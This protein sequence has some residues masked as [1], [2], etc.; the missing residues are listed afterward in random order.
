M[1]CRAALVAVVWLL[2]ITAASAQIDNGSI[3]GFTSDESDAA[4][5]G[6]T[7]TATSS[8][9]MGRRTV[10]SDQH[11]YYRLLDLPP[12]DYQLEAQLAG[13]ARFERRDLVIQAGLS[14]QLDFKMRIG[15][16][17]EAVEVRSEAPILETE[18]AMSTLHLAGDFLRAL[19]L[20][21]GHDW[22]D[23]LR[24]APGAVL[25][26]G[27]GNQVET[28]GATLSSNV[29][30]LDGIDISEP[31]QNWPSFTELSPDSVAEIGIT[32][33]GH[34]AS[35]R[36]AMGAQLGIVTRSGGN[37]THGTATVDL[38]LRGLN[39]TNVPG[40]TPADR[41]ITRPSVS[42]GGPIVR[43]RL[44]Y[45]ATYRYIRERDGVTRTEDDLAVLRLFQ[46]GFSPF[47]A[48]LRSHQS[49]AK[50]TYQPTT[51][52]QVVLS[53]QFN[54]SVRE[55]DALSPRFTHERDGS[56]RSGGPVYS[57]M[58]RRLIGGRAS[59]E[60]QAGFSSKPYENFLQGDGPSLLIFSS[61][62]SSGGRLIGSGAPI[63][64]MGNSQHVTRLLQRRSNVNVT[65]KY[66]P[67]E[68]RGSHELTLGLNLLPKSEYSFLFTSSNGGFILEDRVLLDSANAGRG[69]RPFHRRHVSPVTLAGDGRSS[70]TAGFFAQDSWR[71]GR[72]WVVNAGLRID[73]AETFD[74]WGDSIQSS[75]QS[76]PRLGITYRLTTDGRT[77]VRGALNRMHDAIANVFTFS[78]G[79]LRQELRDE[80]DLDGDGSFERAFTL[81][82]VL[83][84]PS[85]APG[86]NRGLASPGLRQPL[87]DEI[88]L[89]VS[90][91]LPFKIIADASFIHR[92]Y[93]DRMVA[94]DTN[95]IYENGRFLGYRNPMFNQ[96]FEVRNGADNW[97]VYRALEL[98]LQKGFSRDLRF[99]IGYSHAH[100][101]ID[102][103]W[104]HND[105]ASV[106]QPE[107]FPNRKGIGSFVGPVMGQ[108]NSLDPAQFRVVNSGVPPHLLKVN[109]AY[110][111]PFGLAVGLSHL[112]QMGQYSGPI[113]T[114]LPR[115]SV[116]HPPTVTLSN[117]RVVSNPLGTPVRFFYPTR[118]EGQL[119]L[120][121]LNVLNLR[122]G[123]RFKRGSH[124]LEGGLEVFN[125][126][127]QGN[128]LGFNVPTLT[129]GQP[130]AFVLSGT[131]APRAGQIT[132]RWDF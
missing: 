49:L 113:L 129:E 126:F 98:S 18:K 101:W 44:W 7:V 97:F 110:V 52:D 109:V 82:A 96:I 32:T 77:I 13:F 6:V 68:W 62:F 4:L 111:A 94:T 79:S 20:G 107:A 39:A 31:F 25:K 91:Q 19:P 116:P 50:A 108:V 36:M 48:Q 58:W 29:F 125:L 28:H 92:V 76:G 102:G 5:S 10:T 72:R 34:D 73:K 120:P 83:E 90:R 112:F 93:Q 47:D 43:N 30:L 88:A 117:G 61:V 100:Q 105:P 42:V 124:T 78:E 84:R 1:C 66:F 40:G 75:W 106:L 26:F 55:N 95:G 121:S 41:T 86:S 81:P 123:K 33:S 54:R 16:L 37:Q 11:G 27:A 130:A 103:T 24:L 17:A 65:L 22:W 2:S 104:D 119:Q 45:F 46:P 53:V 15:D 71:P 57:S 9:L 128:N 85:P 38:Q 60:A 70:R 99:L 63:V 115:S 64:E 14:I 67:V 35:S 114:L 8:A 12:G 89:G 87:T 118:D 56:A 131:Q 80:Y 74:T 59:I 23:A 3:K 132:V 127:N 51:A 21:A 69:T 122:I